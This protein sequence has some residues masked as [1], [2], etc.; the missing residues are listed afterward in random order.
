MLL[1]QYN[2]LDKEAGKDIRAWKEGMTP[3]QQSTFH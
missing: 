3:R 1:Q 2:E